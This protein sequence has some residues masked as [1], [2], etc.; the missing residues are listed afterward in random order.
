MCQPFELSK[1]KIKG[2]RRLYLPQHLVPKLEDFQQNIIQEIQRDNI[3]HYFPSTPTGNILPT[4][5][6]F[7]YNDNND[8]NVPHLKEI[9]TDN[10]NNTNEFK[11]EHN[12][13]EGKI[14]L[15][16]V[17]PT[18]VEHQDGKSFSDFTNLDDVI[19]LGSERKDNT[20]KTINTGTTTTMQ[21]PKEIHPPTTE[22]EMSTQE[23][24]KE[25]KITKKEVHT[26]DTQQELTQPKQRNGFFVEYTDPLPSNVGAKGNDWELDWQ[27]EEQPESISQKRWNACLSSGWFVNKKPKLKENHN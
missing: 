15:L 1:L 2:P 22:E 10:D 20:N 4:N 21:A 18:S 8:S 19:L 11:D 6:N 5:N 16:P 26:K 7:N 17:Q 13:S 24:R 25:V 23:Q 3:K 12:L 27:K 9:N 14:T